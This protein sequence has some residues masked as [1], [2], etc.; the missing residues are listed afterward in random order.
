LRLV[1][2]RD[3][4]L[5]RLHYAWTPVTFRLTPDNPSRPFAVGTA[6]LPPSA[7]TQACRQNGGVARAIPRPG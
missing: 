6:G 5:D 2:R 1:A 4:G 3:D 7:A